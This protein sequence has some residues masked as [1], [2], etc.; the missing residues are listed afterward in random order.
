MFAVISFMVA[1]AFCVG[2]QVRKSLDWVEYRGSGCLCWVVVD[3]DVLGGENYPRVLREVA[4]DPLP[5]TFRLVDD[6]AEL[7][8]DAD[9]VVFCGKRDSGGKRGRKATIWLSPT[10]GATVISDDIV[11]VGEFSAASD[12]WESANVCEV[13]GAAAYIPSWPR[14]VCSALKSHYHE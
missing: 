11:I 1:K 7:P 10:A 5:V 12:C 13:S 4:A 8:V 2:S 14:E 6:A 3:P 9:F